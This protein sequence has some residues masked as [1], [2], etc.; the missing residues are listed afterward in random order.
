M[1]DAQRRAMYRIRQLT[2]YV[3]GSR[4]PSRQY[5]VEQAVDEK[6]LMALVHQG[7]LPKT[8]FHYEMAQP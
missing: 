6:T 8:Q 5:P 7:F 2:R 4:N 1:T 3:R